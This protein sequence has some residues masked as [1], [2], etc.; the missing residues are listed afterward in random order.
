MQPL[1]RPEV[2]LVGVLVVVVVVVVAVAVGRTEGWTEWKG[3]AQMEM[4]W[5]MTA[6]GDEMG[7]SRTIMMEGMRD[8]RRWELPISDER[9]RLR[10]STRQDA[11]VKEVDQA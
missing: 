11:R 6:S 7:Q 3:A 1:K 2:G 9:T 5:L 4:D 10:Q 8:G